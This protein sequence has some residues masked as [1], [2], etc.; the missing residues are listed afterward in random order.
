MSVVHYFEPKKSVNSVCG[1]YA[2]YATVIA[3]EVTCPDCLRLLNAPAVREQQAR[4]EAAIEQEAEKQAAEIIAAATKGPPGTVAE[5]L[6]GIEEIARQEVSGTMQ[7]GWYERQSK[8]ISEEVASWPAW[9]KRAAGLTVDNKIVA[10]ERP[11]TTDGANCRDCGLP[12]LPENRT[13]ADGC[14][15]NSSR[16][17]NH[18][19]VPKET[20]T[21]C[22]CDPAQTGSS[23]FGK[24][25][26][27]AKL[28]ALEER[29]AAL[30]RW[31]DD[32]MGR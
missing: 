13:M 9:M 23:R 26:D 4:I 32:S 19:L 18:G 7:P 28:A 21:C 30:E 27:G 8:L 31:R 17:V 10:P 2:C 6:P 3:H 24:S 20:C 14:P 29:I 15:C 25:S 5:L 11:Q 16:G 22:L 1:L 12:L